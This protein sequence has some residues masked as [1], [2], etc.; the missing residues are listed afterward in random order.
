MLQLVKTVH[1]IWWTKWENRWKTLNTVSGKVRIQYMLLPL[2]FYYYCQDHKRNTFRY[3][4]LFI[5]KIFIEQLLEAG[6]QPGPWRWLS[7]TGHRGLDTGKAW[8]MWKNRGHFDWSSEYRVHGW[9]QMSLQRCQGHTVKGL[10]VV[11]KIP[12]FKA[13]LYG[14]KK[15]APCLQGH[16]WI[17]SYSLVSRKCSG[18][19]P[20]LCAMYSSTTTCTGKV[21]RT[22]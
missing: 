20:Y 7:Y 6:H 8:H 4:H 13:H 14:F 9:L 2:L 5:S 1:V 22:L 12:D 3:V 10:C 21:Y 17:S 15:W 16:S 18:F 11:L 19:H